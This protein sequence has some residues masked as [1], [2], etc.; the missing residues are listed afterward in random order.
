MLR[1]FSLVTLSFVISLPTLAQDSLNS[2]FDIDAKITNRRSLKMNKDLLKKIDTSGYCCMLLDVSE[3]GATENISVSYCTHKVLESQA[4]KR[5]SELRFKPATKD[6]I[7][8]KRHNKDLT[9]GF[10]KFKKRRGWVIPGP[11]GYM[12]PLDQGNVIPPRPKKLAERKKW[13]R[14]YFNNNKICT[15]YV[16]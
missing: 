13:L 1:L 9:I 3:N 8:V 11:N 12:R 15:P 7:V 16:S 14:K 5:M 6:G 10:N 2:E 4:I